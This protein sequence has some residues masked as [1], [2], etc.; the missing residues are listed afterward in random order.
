MIYAISDHFCRNMPHSTAQ[1]PEKAGTVVPPT[2]QERVSFWKNA[3]ATTSYRTMSG[4]DDRVVGEGDDVVVY[5]GV[6]Q[7]MRTVIESVH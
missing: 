3:F 6:G 2:V 7:R 1:N 4:H 5:H